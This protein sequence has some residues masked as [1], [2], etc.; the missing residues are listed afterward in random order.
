MRWAV[1]G[2]RPVRAASSPSPR[3]SAPLLKAATNA[4][5][6]STAWAPERDGASSAPLPD[7]VAAMGQKYGGPALLPREPLAPPPRAPGASTTSTTPPAPRRA[8]VARHRFDVSQNR[9]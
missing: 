8:R 9:R 2:R 1:L 4:T 3:L 7:P 5:A 6:R